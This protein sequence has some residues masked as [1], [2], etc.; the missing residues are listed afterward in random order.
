MLS[1]KSDTQVYVL[2]GLIYLKFNDRENTALIEVLNHCLLRQ[3]AAEVAG[4]GGR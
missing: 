2:Y 4:I 3:E 1:E